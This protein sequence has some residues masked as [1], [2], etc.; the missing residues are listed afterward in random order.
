MSTLNLQFNVHM[1]EDV[2]LSPSKIDAVCNFISLKS[3]HN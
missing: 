3:E 2:L 1:S